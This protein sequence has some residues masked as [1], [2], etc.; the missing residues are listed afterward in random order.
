MNMNNIS[1]KTIRL[2]F[3]MALAAMV[4]ILSPAK[5]RADDQM[6]GGPHMLHLQ[7]IK[8]TAEAEAL[9][10]GETMAMVCTKCKSVMVNNVTTEKGH[11]K[12]MTVGEK[13]L[14]PGCDSTIKVVGVGK[15]KHGE[16]RHSCEKCGDKSVFC[17][18][19]KP[20]SAPTAGME[21]ENKSGTK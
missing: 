15:G 3:C 4:A 5:A 6:K 1:S 18:A 7:G 19:T 16:V 10:P 2:C 12:T 8:T 21:E 11:I 20:G 13:H 17:C 14:C 9:K